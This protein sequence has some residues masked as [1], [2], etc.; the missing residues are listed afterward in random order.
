[1]NGAGTIPKRYPAAL[2]IPAI[3]ISYLFH[4]VF[5]PT[6]MCLVLYKLMPATF[7]GIQP[8]EFTFVVI[9]FFITTAFFPILITVLCKALGF[10]ESIHL[11]TTKDRII[12][13]LGTMICYFWMN[14]VVKNL[15]YPELLHALSLG[16]FWTV[17]AAF[18]ANIFVKISLHA[19]AAGGM[20]GI[21]LVVLFVSP[22]NLVLPFFL[23]LLVAGVIGT[24]RLIL[25]AHRGADIWLGYFT[26][27]LSMVAAYWYL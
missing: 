27:I 1:M 5:M 10:V 20:L 8:R 9:R 18:M 25:Q 12:P 14:L 3:L 23:G 2:R 13:M 19:V 16:S 11:E 6:V 24:A 4:P 22:V 21:L 26:G 7:V 15:G 17:I